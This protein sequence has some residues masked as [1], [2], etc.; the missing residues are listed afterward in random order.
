[1][2][3]QDTTNELSRRERQ[4]MNIIYQL[5]EATAPEI[6]E[7]M[8]DPP[9]DAAVRFTLRTLAEKGHVGYRRVGQR[10]VYRPTV[11]RGKAQKSALQHLVQTFF[12]GS[13]EHAVTTLL[14]MQ[15]SRLSPEELE[16][17]AAIIEEMRSEGR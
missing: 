3:R 7:Q 11:A 10:Y 4:V 6:R 5:D 12:E 13:T 2:T 17:M 8:T 15:S 1:M 9:S 14:E 16:R